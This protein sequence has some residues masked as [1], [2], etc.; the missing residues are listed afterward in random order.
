MMQATDMREFDYCALLWRLDN[1]T[2]R[3]ILV[4]GQMSSRTVVVA[5]IAGKD[6]F[7]MAFSQPIF[8]TV[9][10]RTPINQRLGVSTD[11]LMALH[12]C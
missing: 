9:L 12:G 3:R 5:H 6:T 4:Q 8:N 2:I 7:E 1:P 10:N 11:T